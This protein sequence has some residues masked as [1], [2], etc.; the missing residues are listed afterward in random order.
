[1]ELPTV[2]SSTSI[3]KAVE[4]PPVGSNATLAAWAGFAD[5]SVTSATHAGSTSF[6]NNI[7]VVSSDCGCRASIRKI[8]VLPAAE[9][10]NHALAP[11]PISD[12]PEQVLASQSAK[13]EPAH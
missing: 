8:P 2:G 12:G 9:P 3:R 10:T 5:A 1:M 6:L 11:T 4:P 13:P 7:F